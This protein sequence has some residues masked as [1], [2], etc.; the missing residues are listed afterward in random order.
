LPLPRRFRGTSAE[1]RLQ[2]RDALNAQMLPLS[3][4]G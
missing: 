4:S 3:E 1:A 2:R